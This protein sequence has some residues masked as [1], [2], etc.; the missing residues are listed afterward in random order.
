MRFTVLF[1][2]GSVDEKVVLLLRKTPF[3]AI[4][5]IIHLGIL[6]V[7]MSIKFS[8]E[9]EGSERFSFELKTPVEDMSLTEENDILGEISEEEIELAEMEKFEVHH[10]LLEMD[11][12][13]LE[14]DQ[15]F[16]TQIS[17]EIPIPCVNVVCK[18]SD[19]NESA[20]DDYIH[21]TIKGD[22][23]IYSGRMPAR[24][25]GSKPGQGG[26]GEGGLDIIGLGGG[27]GGFSGGM[28]G[29][30]FGGKENLIARAGGDPSK[31]E[32]LVLNALK[33]LARHQN[34]EGYWD[35][36]Q[37]TNACGGNVLCS[38]VGQTDIHNVGLTGLAL[39]AFLGYGITPQVTINNEVWKDDN[40]EKYVYVDRYTNKRINVT[41]VV[42]KGLLWLKNNQT[43]KGCFVKDYELSSNYMYDH[44]IAT[45]A[46]AEAC[47]LTWNRTWC[48]SAREGVSFLISG[49]SPY[50]GW[51]YV[52]Q[53]KDSDISVTGWAIMALKSAQGSNK[54]K[55]N[56]EIYTNILSW[57]DKRMIMSDDTY[58][59]MYIEEGPLTSCFDSEINCNYGG[60]LSMTAV[61]ML[62]RMLS[63][64]EGSVKG[65]GYKILKEQGKQL[66]TDL[67][68]TNIVRKDGKNPR[69]Y[70]YWYYATLALYLLDSPKEGF[71]NGSLG[72]WKI[73]N[74]E[75]LNTLI[76][77]QESDKKLCSFGSFPAKNDK[78]G[79]Y[80][81]RVY[82]T[83]INALTMEV[84]FR[85][86]NVFNSM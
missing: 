72:H 22:G 71:S 16:D 56:K 19:H 75:I 31:V 65:E 45:L 14:R 5:L 78:W 82:A 63:D 4:S 50:G 68:T 9:I 76:K 35:G 23:L 17:R 61:G 27:S 66:M 79:M 15:R 48:E 57:M 24:G 2:E 59:V 7:L 73:W 18:E 20:N 46:M 62:I 36:M 81:G 69:D 54:V 26:Q 8:K 77:L 85:Y 53:S 30:R 70:Y 43:S 44:A 74:R 12:T 25:S 80:I 40:K 37:F 58:R 49:K 42:R 60:E 29:Y 41:E 38:D 67:P 10:D 64:P 55:I 21:N 3:I 83:A 84:Y 51:R 33:W 39:L 86:K 6:V 1:D 28:F 34:D 32:T 13:K 11:F 47:G 52:W